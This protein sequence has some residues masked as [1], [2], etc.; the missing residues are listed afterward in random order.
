MAKPI[1][2]VGGPPSSSIRLVVAPAADDR[3]LRA[4]A[5]RHDLEHGVGVVVEAAHQSI[6]DLDRHAAALERRQH[7]AEVTRARFAQAL[8]EARRRGEQLDLRRR[9]GVEDAQRVGLEAAPA[10][11]AQLGGAR[12][13]VRAQP[14]AIGGA[15]LG[16]THGVDQGLEV[17]KAELA[18]EAHQQQDDLGVGPRPRVADQLGADLMELAVAT[19]LRALVA[20]LR[21]DVEEPHR[22]RPL[23]QAVLGEGAR[24]RRGVLRSQREA[25]AVL[26]GEGV[27]LLADDVGALAHAAHEE[28]GLLDDRRADLGEAV[29]REHRRARSI[30]PAPTPRSREGVGPSCP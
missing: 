18:E 13:Q 29:A 10:V 20:E 21:A 25:L 15:T 16:V 28:L 23:A 30:R 2:G 4:E 12:Q 6:G 8:L 24:H 19:A 26:V 5:G 22:L 7:V 9:L 11:L 1:A 3:V 27:H 17:A 14:L